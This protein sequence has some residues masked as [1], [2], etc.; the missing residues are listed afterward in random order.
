MKLFIGCASSNDI[1]NCYVDDCKKLIEKLLTNNTLIYGAY[2]EGLMGECFNTAKKNNNKVIGVCPKT[3]EEDSKKL[4][5]DEIIITDNIID[6]TKTLLN[7]CDAII[8]L[9]GGIGTINEL[10]SSIDSKRSGELNKKIV[11]FNSNHY[12]D[13]LLE[14]LDKLYAEKFSDKSIK[15]CYLVTDNID[16]VLNYLKG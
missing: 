8:L 1:D 10:F 11:I 12:Y 13:K 3:Y 9:P 4:N 2:N 14:F 15:D 7:I 6:R 16:E 5:C